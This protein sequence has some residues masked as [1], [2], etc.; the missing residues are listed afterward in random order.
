MLW[1]CNA[2]KT[3]GI[4]YLSCAFPE[5]KRLHILHHVL[6]RW[7]AIRGK[8]FVCPHQMQN[9]T[10]SIKNHS[11]SEEHMGRLFPKCSA[12][13]ET[14]D[15]ILKSSLIHKYET[16][17]KWSKI[18]TEGLIQSWSLHTFVGS[19][20]AQFYHLFPLVIF[21]NWG[22]LSTVAFSMARKCQAK[23]YSSSH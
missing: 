15:H 21:K 10:K 7:N 9:M 19:H 14:D 16:I 6:T 1:N 13:N 23:W 12:H 5:Q 22:K 20:W 4:N 17:L 18:H 11:Q 3:Y 8:Q 2:V